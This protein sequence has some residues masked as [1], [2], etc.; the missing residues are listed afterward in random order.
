MIHTNLNE[1]FMKKIIGIMI[2]LI[3]F[4]NPEIIHSQPS[5]PIEQWERKTILLIAA[6]PDDDYQ[7]HGTL[8][9]LK[10][11][12]NKIFILTLT[13]GNVGTRDPKMNKN[14]LSKI[15]RQEQIEAMKAIGLSEQQYINLGYDDGRVEFADKEEIIGKIVY[16]IRK[17]RPDVLM[18]FDPGFNY[19]VW[20][21]SDHRAAAYLTADAVRAAEWRLMYE[22]QIIHQNLNAYSVPEFLF[23]GGN[24][25][26]KNFEVDITEYLDKK[27]LAGSKYL[28]QWSSG[29]NNYLGSD[30]NDY[31]IGEKDS[32][33]NRLKR[34]IKY[35][36]NIPLERFRYYKGIPDA[37][38]RE[39]R[40]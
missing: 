6:H 28:S 2:F 16:H 14:D 27:I 33:F 31:P 38:G 15:R 36:N 29:W 23:Y 8:A 9:L 18:S 39:K 40:D 17:I 11:N 35:Q 3:A 19:P 10:N 34:R 4:A 25:K 1:L 26:D 20:H 32:V 21:K 22:G 5:T 30:L 13:T 12:K 37:M 7:S 24:I